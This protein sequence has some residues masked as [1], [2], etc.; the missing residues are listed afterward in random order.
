M[1]DYSG[2]FHL[3]P[4]FSCIRTIILPTYLAIYLRKDSE[5]ILGVE[6]GV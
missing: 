4:I 1:R 3:G 6:K 2:V 5:E